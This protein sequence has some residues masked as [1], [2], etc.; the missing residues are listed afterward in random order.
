METFDDTLDP[1]VQRKIFFETV[2]GDDIEDRQDS[3]EDILR[4][5]KGYN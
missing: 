4:E 3:I 2:L 5:K 1:Y